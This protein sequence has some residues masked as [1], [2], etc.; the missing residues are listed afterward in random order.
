MK[1]VRLLGI[2]GVAAGLLFF[3]GAGKKP[4]GREITVQGTLHLMAAIG[5][6]TTGWSLRLDQPLKVKEGMRVGQIEIDPGR[7][8][9][10]PFEGQ[11]VEIAGVLSWKTGIERGPYP[12]VVIKTIRKTP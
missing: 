11:R 7:K 9:L 10:D 2:T 12:V 3:I 6:E 5:G 8:H 1:W 4:A